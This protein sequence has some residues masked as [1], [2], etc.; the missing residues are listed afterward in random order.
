[1]EQ[2][3]F[4]WGHE[5]CSKTFGQISLGLI[6]VWR[7]QNECIMLVLDYFMGRRIKHR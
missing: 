1:L 6:I 2:V 7:I 4:I 3:I 5:Q